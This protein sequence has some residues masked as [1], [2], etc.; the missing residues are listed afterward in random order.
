[1]HRAIEKANR[2]RVSTPS[3]LLVH[4]PFARRCV[5]MVSVVGAANQ[6]IVQ[7]PIEERSE[8]GGINALI[9]ELRKQEVKVHVALDARIAVRPFG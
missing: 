3:A 9:Q 5:R 6:A 4:M 2:R 7:Q 1:M 8:R